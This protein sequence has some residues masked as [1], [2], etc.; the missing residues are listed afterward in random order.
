MPVVVPLLL[1]WAVPGGVLLEH[2]VIDIGR[3]GDLEVAG[4]GAAVGQMERIRLV[5][6]AAGRD[7]AAGHGGGDQVGQDV[8]HA[9]DLL[10]QNIVVEGAGAA[11]AIG[12]VGSA[13]V[14]VVPANLNSRARDEAGRRG[15]RL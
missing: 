14:L 8:A 4:A 6:G 15:R 3:D 2:L 1:V 12:G 11:A 13:G 10:H 7:D 5:I 9:V